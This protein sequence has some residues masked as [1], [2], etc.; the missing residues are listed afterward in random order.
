MNEAPAQ[1][2]RAGLP[3]LR[4]GLVLA[5]RMI[6]LALAVTA[7]AL[8]INSI[9]AGDVHPV[10]LGL[11]M[12][13]VAVLVSV[14]IILARRRA[15]DP[16][17]ALLS[18]ALLTWAVSSSFDFTAS[19]LLPML[20]ERLRYWLFL[21]A[22]LL[23]PD[24]QW[25]PRWTRGVAAAGTAV[26][27]LGV[28]EATG[29]IASAYYLPLAIACV[30]G[31]IAALITRFRTTEAQTER[32]QLK[33]VALG[34]VLGVG[35][36]LTARAGDA[37]T[38][39]MAMPMVVSVGFEG[40]FQLGIIVI[41]LGFFVSLLRYRLFDAEAAITHSAAYAA[42]TLA[43]VGTFAGSEALIEVL[44]QRYLGQGIGDVSAAIA[45]AIAAVLLTPLHDRLRDWAERHFERDLAGLKQ[46]LPELIDELAPGAST[47]SLAAA[48]LPKIQDA[49]HATRACLVVERSIAAASGIGP[50]EARRWADRH[51]PAEVGDLFACDASDRLFPIRMALRC[52]YGGVRGWLLLGP[53]PDGSFYGAN[54]FGAL[55]AVAPTL[56]RG[57]FMVKSRDD[58][59][60]RDRRLFRDLRA[61]LD[62][63]A[64]DV[65]SQ[66]GHGDRTADAG[67]GRMGI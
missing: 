54:E 38:A 46:Q 41:A 43:L 52:P 26:F 44:G 35:L 23:F 59:R 4:G 65:A 60:A 45:A 20:I 15:N 28:A 13:K 49:I 19:G 10:V 29:L 14:C 1:R 5:F 16:V 50:R 64:C 58:E 37:L 51:L 66:K 3:P 39:S 17:A 57:L 48:V 2:T 40:L 62:G 42:L 6:G 31:A 21:L 61:K 9:V 30:L 63:L 33:W 27:V 12:V 67:Q 55:S 22:L 25:R 36:I 53:R 34:L 24:G 8:L 7:A 32:Q 47:K 11:R 18:L 56:R